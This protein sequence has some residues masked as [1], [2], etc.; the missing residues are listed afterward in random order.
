M[1]CDR[2][3]RERVSART[4]TAIAAM[5]RLIEFNTVDI[6]ENCQS[7]WYEVVYSWDS[8]SNTNKKE[9]LI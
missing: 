2:S 9:K 7:E 6:S 4:L 1:I 5:G 3:L 8:Q